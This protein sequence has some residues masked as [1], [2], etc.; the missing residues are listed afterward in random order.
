MIGILFLLLLGIPIAELYVIIQV[1]Q[2]IGFL[3]TLGL[4][5]AISAA[6]AYLLRYQGMATWKRLQATMARGEVPTKEVTDG[7][8]IVI[9]GALLLTP[10]FIT[11]AVGL[12]LLF[13]P[14][15]AAIKGVARKTFG[16]M[17]QRRTR[18]MVWG[19]GGGQVHDT[20]AR[21]GATSNEGDARPTL[22]E[23]EDEDG[24]PGT[25]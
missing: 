20:T 19:S 24:S 7:A 2:G 11:D 18:I 8:L 16:R 9:G 3:E 22:R 23:P 15:R 17:A 10:G 12:L 5:I 4:L 6:G 14:T 1:S 25:R 13:P 21:P